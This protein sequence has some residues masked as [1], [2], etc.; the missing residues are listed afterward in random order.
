MIENIFYVTGCRFHI[1]DKNMLFI[2]GT[3]RE[4]NI[5]DQKIISKL[6]N[7]ELDM[8]VK[9]HEVNVPHTLGK[10]LLTKQY[11][12]W[13][14]LPNEWKK[15]K[16]LYIFQSNGN[17]DRVVKKLSVKTLERMSREIP[18]NVDLITETDGMFKIRGWYIDT[19][20]TIQKFESKNKALNV[21]IKEVYRA[22]VLEVY[23][24]CKEE[25]IV[26]FEALVKSDNIKVVKIKYKTNIEESYVKLYMNQKSIFNKIDKLGKLID[27]AND[28]FRQYGA[29]RTVE[30]I[31]NKLLKKDG[32]TYEQWL[33]IN[34]PNHSEL[35]M[36]KQQ[37]FENNPKISIVVPLYRTPKKYLKEFIKSVMRQTYSNW[38]LCLSDGSGS[39]SP[40]TGVLKEYEK[41]DKRIK[42]VYNKEPLQISENTNAALEIATG[43]YI[44]FADHDDLLAPNAFYECVK[45]INKNPE[46]EMIYTDEDKITMDGKQHFM[47]HF[48]TDFNLDLLRSVNY[49]CHLCVV[50]KSLYE[51]VGKLNSEFD[52]AQD[53]DFVFR[54]I[55]KTKNIVHIPKILYHWRAHKDSTAENPESKNYAFEAGRRAIAA[56][57]KRMGIEGEVFSLEMKGSY[58]VK[59]KLKEEP[60][61]SVIIPTKDHIDDLDKCLKSLEEINAYDNIEYIIV[62]NNSEKE[63]TFEYYKKIEKENLKVKVVYWKEKGFN[64]PSINNLGVKSSKGDYLLFLNNDTEIRNA[65]CIEELVSQC[66]RKEVGAVGA[67]L[68]YEDGTIQHAGVIIGVGGV[69]GHAFLGYDHDASGYFGR[70]KLLQDYSAVTAACIMVKRKVYEE[71]KGFD[72]EYAVAFNDVDLCLKICQAGYLIVYD[73][74]VE[75]NHY[76]SKSRGYEDTEEKI[77]RFN[78]EIALF[79]KRWK[80][81]LKAGDPYYNPNLTLA[82]NDFSLAEEAR[83]NI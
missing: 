24:E 83:E 50:K 4:N 40:I 58:R 59:Y 11:H 53:Y 56:H 20:N 27:K 63:E 71:V 45:I 60:L 82:R 39:N 64:Y 49:I 77:R 21:K 8:S 15:N 81:F 29:S 19:G 54:C 37:V 28:S 74:Y 62:E 52:G 17:K 48:K 78:S 42:V 57:L 68:Y 32:L 79:Q 6:D 33:K 34:M 55:E 38:E 5:Y 41:K 25:N 75:L 61:V 73:P 46:V 36:Q 13:V 7:Q 14:K 18:N 69:A 35:Q 9:E 47:P 10:D 16:Q 31:R 22:D 44:A 70:I 23:E 2:A 1:Y 80:T 67:R 26:G 65:D 12:L 43:D 72:E 66:Q 51:K 30:K 3:F 76:E